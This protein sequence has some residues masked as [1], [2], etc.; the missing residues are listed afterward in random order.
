[1]T[2]DLSR[3]LAAEFLGTF[4]LVF[5]AVGTAVVAGAVDFGLVAVA[6]AFGLVLVFGAYAFGPVS[7]CHV[8]PAVTIAMIATKRIDAV[9][10]GLYIVVQFLG[11]W[12]AP[13]CSG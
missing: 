3:K 6:L 1:M 5:L 9:V 2:D 10:G 12:S 8:N 11:V 13:S 7:G 4:A